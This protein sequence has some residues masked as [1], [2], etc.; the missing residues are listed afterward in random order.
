VDF[1]KT[2]DLVVLFNLASKVH[3]LDMSIQTVQPLN[4]YSIEARY[5]GD[6]DYVDTKEVETAL[7]AARI[8]R[9]AIRKILASV[10]SNDTLE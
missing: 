4:R 8:V 5:P 10:L 9:T 6:W 2:H 3:P 1:P 7:D